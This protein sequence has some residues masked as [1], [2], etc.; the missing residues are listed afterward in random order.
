MYV[1]RDTRRN[2]NECTYIE[3]EKIEYVPDVCMYYMFLCMFVCLSVCM[4]MYI[5]L[6]CSDPRLSAARSY[7]HQSIPVD[8]ETKRKAHHATTALLP[9]SKRTPPHPDLNFQP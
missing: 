6:I 7:A 3:T 2:N 8:T 5:S 4:Y 1:H 9:H